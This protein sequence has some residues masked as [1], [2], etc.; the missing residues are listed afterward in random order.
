[1]GRRSFLHRGRRLAADQVE[2]DLVHRR[3]RCAS[4]R[5]ATSGA[6]APERSAAEE[7]RWSQAV[8]SIA[9]QLRRARTFLLR[10]GEAGQLSST[11]RDTSDGRATRRSRAFP[12]RTKPSRPPPSR[13]TS[14]P[15][16]PLCRARSPRAR[17]RSSRWYAGGSARRSRSRTCRTTT[18]GESGPRE[19]T[20]RRARLP[21]EYASA[22]SRGSS[23][24]TARRPGRPRAAEVAPELDGASACCRR[25]APSQ[26]KLFAERNIRLPPR[27]RY[28]CTASWVL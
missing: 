14:S 7:S 8:R 22:R 18:V 19:R 15:R 24:R 12:L 27:S 2:R 20:A 25:A 16:R 21:H 28:F 11:S 5:R 1:M 13:S 4:R 6:D 23:R 17:G 3:D 26:K 9:S 10:R